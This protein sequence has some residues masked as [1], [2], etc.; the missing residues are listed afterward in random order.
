MS[1]LLYSADYYITFRFIMQLNQVMK[2]DMNFAS[3]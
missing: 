1:G 3:D 2:L